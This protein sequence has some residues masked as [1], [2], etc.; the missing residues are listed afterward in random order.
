MARKLYIFYK[1]L[2]NKPET[3]VVRENGPQ[4][5]L[6][7]LVIRVCYRIMMVNLV[8]YLLSKKMI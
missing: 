3:G 6:K 5:I 8:P 4:N 1:N 7:M 2:P